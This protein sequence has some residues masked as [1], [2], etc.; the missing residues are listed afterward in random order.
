M[1]GIDRMLKPTL[2]LVLPS[3]AGRY[4]VLLTL[5]SVA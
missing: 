5:W 2:V 1:H 3:T 4:V